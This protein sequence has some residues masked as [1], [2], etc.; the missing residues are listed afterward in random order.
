MRFIRVAAIGAR[1]LVLVASFASASLLNYVF[2]LAAGWLLGP[3]DFGLLAFAQTLLLIGGLILETGI[4]WSLARALAH[5]PPTAQA[6]LVRGALVANVGLALCLASL[7]AVL[8][9]A[10]P[11]CAGLEQFSI[12][13]VVCISLVCIA[14]STVIRGALQGVER[15]WAV[16][17]VQISEV[18]SKTCAGLG[19]VLLGQGVV[20][21]LAGFAIG[22]G[23]AICL[24]LW[25]ARGLLR[26]HPSARALDLPR[27]RPAVSIFGAL[28][29]FALLLNLDLLAVKL[30]VPDQ[31]ALAGYYQAAIMLANLPCYLVTAAIVPLLLR[32]WPVRVASRAPAPFLG[33]AA[34]WSP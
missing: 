19:L 9:I 6:G 2:G 33:W 25:L 10:G 22:G 20:G 31:R 21:A 23:V 29:A 27:L 7:V 17:A 28:I 13:L 1:R 24:S 26:P 5:A 14:V 32:G 15:F 11:F 12:L 16:A 18:S 4:P 30:L 3:A 8:F 34:H